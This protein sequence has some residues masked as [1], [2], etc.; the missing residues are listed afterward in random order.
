[1]LTQAELKEHFEYNPETGFFKAIKSTNRRIRIG[2]YFPR[3]CDTSKYGYIQIQ[4]KQ[5]GAHRLAWL[6]VYGN[7]PEKQIDHINHLKKDNRICNLRLATPSENQMHKPLYKNN[8]T[9]FKGVTKGR[10]GYVA[11]G[12]LN[13][14]RIWLGEYKDINLAAKAYQDFAKEHHG[15]FYHE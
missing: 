13:G 12:Y 3:V 10:V 5:Y 11:Q 2:D 7:F 15:E 1:M 8:T 4:G 14:N 6:Y 9:G